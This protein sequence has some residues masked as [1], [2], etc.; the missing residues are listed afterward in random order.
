MGTGYKA[1]EAKYPG[2]KVEVYRASGS[3]LAVRMTEEARARRYIVDALETTRD[4]LTS[5]RETGLLSAFN[6]PYIRSYSR[7]TPHGG[8]SSRP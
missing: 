1:F 8:L 4:T 3:E 7:G 2:V 5:L 6:S